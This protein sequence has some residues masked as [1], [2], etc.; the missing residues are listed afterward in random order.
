GID[1]EPKAV[2]RLL[3][4]KAERLEHPALQ[5]GVIDTDRTAANLHTIDDEVIGPGS[6]VAGV[7]LNLVKVGELRRGKRMV[8]GHIPPL[9]L[10]VFKQWE[11]GH[12][13]AFKP[14]RLD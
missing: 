14:A 6:S 3:F 2:L 8:F 11:V 10:A 12:P 9:L 4:R 7:A 13:E 1:E 5:I